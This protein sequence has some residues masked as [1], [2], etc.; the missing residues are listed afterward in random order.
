MHSIGRENLTSV[1]NLWF[2]QRNWASLARLG[3]QN[4]GNGFDF[5]VLFTF[6][7]V[8]LHALI[9]VIPNKIIVCGDGSIF[10][11][12]LPDIVYNSIVATAPLDIKAC[13]NI[14]YGTQPRVASSN[15]T[16]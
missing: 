13:E 6:Q 2:R 16:I 5:S 15:R 11:A 8:F 4:F 10:P 3:C 12:D 14:I 1:K 9:I 7:L